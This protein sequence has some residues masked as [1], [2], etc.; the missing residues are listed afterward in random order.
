MNEEENMLGVDEL[1][2]MLVSYAGLSAL[3]IKEKILAQAIAFAAGQANA[4]DL[5][6]VVMK[7]R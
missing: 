6:F 5:T 2:N 4:D 1:K 3:E 7:V